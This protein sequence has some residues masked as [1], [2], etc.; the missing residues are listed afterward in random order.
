MKDL[1][2]K[3][4]QRPTQIYLI[5]RVFNLTSPDIGMRVYVD[6]WRFR[7]ILLNFEAQTWTVMPTTEV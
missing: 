1:Q 5:I 7:G 3:P 2:I 6:P 4:D